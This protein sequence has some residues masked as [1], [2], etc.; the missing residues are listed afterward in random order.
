MRLRVDKNH[1]FCN[2][3][4]QYHIMN[5][6]PNLQESVS[7]IMCTYNGEK[8]LR[9]QIESTE[10]FAVIGKPNA[11]L[12][13][14]AVRHLGFQPSELVFLGDNLTTDAPAAAEAG[15]PFI[16]TGGAGFRLLDLVD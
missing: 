16:H 3:K 1:Y 9:A 15:I 10:P 13:E 12:V 5:E 7:I 8:Y 4:Y 2:K 14:R 6:C 11:A